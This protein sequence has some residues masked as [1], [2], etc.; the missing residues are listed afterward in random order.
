MKDYFVTLYA[1]LVSNINE[2]HGMEAVRFIEKQK[3]RVKLRHGINM[4][5]N[6]SKES[7]LY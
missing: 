2:P 7:K 3:R 4:F 6:L 5:F 1:L